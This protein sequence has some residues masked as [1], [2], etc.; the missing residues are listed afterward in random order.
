MIT[1]E[2]FANNKKVVIGALDVI[3]KQ[4]THL[5]NEEASLSIIP[6]V[7]DQILDR[8][9]EL[10]KEVFTIEG[11]VYSR[12]E[13]MECLVEE[14]SLL[15]VLNISGRIQGFVY[16]YDDDE[17]N[18]VVEGTDYFLD[19]A[20]MALAYENKGIGTLLSGVILLLVYLLGFKKIGITTEMKDKT[21][22]ELVKFYKKLGFTEAST[23]E[24][25]D[26]GMKIILDENLINGICSKLHISLNE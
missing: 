13:I 14:Y 6:Q 5:L 9:I 10:E 7:N 11:N 21:G 4:L 26:V 17:D 12:E 3:N 22:R 1:L 2:S 20:V 23:A 19:S 16:G 18:P 8:M 24:P 25:L 15:L